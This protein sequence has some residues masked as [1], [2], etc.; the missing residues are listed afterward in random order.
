MEELDRILTYTQLKNDAMHELKTC[1]LDE[2]YRKKVVDLIE[3][4]DEVSENMIYK[5]GKLLN[6]YE[7][8]YNDYKLIKIEKE[9]ENNKNKKS[10]IIF[11]TIQFILVLGII[12]L[13]K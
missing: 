5:Y 4:L 8:L 9:Q 11:S 2:N 6:D 7:N 1:E 3:S 12:F 10:F 13:G